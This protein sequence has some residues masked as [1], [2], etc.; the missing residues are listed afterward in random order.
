MNESDLVEVRVI[1]PSVLDERNFFYKLSNKGVIK[2]SGLFTDYTLPENRVVMGYNWSEEELKRWDE[3]LQ[4]EIGRDMPKKPRDIATL[5]YF[6]DTNNGFVCTAEAN[7][8]QVLSWTNY[9]I[10]NSTEPQKLE[11]MILERVKE[12][13]LQQLFDYNR[14]ARIIELMGEYIKKF[15][16][17]DSWRETEKS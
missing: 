8:P 17:A 9:N 14:D 3:R 15:G 12:L 11:Y 6:Q 13:R 4:T 2:T 7:K 1:K 16:N 5:Y 10:N